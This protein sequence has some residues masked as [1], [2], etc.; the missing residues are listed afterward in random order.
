MDTSPCC[1]SL[2]LTIFQ[3]DKYYCHYL[4][5]EVLSL[6]IRAGYEGGDIAPHQRVM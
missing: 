2:I 6:A 5:N 1:G 4:N 3:F